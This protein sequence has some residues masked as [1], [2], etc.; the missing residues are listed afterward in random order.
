MKTKQLSESISKLGPLLALIA[1]VA[2]VTALNQ[3]FYH[4]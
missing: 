2:A 3:A 4:Q 1:L